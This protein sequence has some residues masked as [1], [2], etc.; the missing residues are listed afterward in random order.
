MTGKTF[1]QIYEFLKERRV[2]FWDF[3]GVIKDSVVVKSKGYEKLFLPYGKEIVNRVNQHHEDHGGIS[4]Y[5]KIPLYL[6]W[7]GE[8]ANPDQVQDFCDRFSKLVLQ[9][10]VDSPWVPGVREYLRANCVQQCFILITATPQKEIER[11]LNALNIAFCFREV[12]GAPRTKSLVVKDV[13]KRLHFSTEQALVI[14]D[15]GTD[16]EVAKENNVAFL[17]RCTQQNHNLQEIYSGPR[18][19]YLKY[20]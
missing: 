19:E 15:S 3:D 10:V 16:L 8:P 1:K 7:A 5:K 18:F 4:R 13:L 2:L 6:D 14:G 12:H 11:I 20:E 17:L 9:A